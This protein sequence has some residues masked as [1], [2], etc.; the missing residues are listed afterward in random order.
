MLKLSLLLQI[1]YKQT[2]HD[3]ECDF[4]SKIDRISLHG[5]DNINK[6]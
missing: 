2:C 6:T 4:W 5:Q 3:N 1:S